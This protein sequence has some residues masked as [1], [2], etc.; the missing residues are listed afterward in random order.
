MTDLEIIRRCAE[1]MGIE[2]FGE[3]GESD[4]DTIFLDIAREGDVV[5]YNPLTDDAQCMALVKKFRITVSNQEGGKWGAFKNHYDCWSE[6]ADLN[7]AVCE[8]VARMP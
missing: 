7:R 1:K 3:Y 4:T 5:E 6:N 8:C 2:W